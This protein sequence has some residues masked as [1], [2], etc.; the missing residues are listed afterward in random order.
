M[1][2][3]TAVRSYRESRIR[4]NGFGDFA[5]D[6]S[7]DL[8]PKNKRGLRLANPV[9]TA[10]GTF[11]NGLEMASLFDIQRL[12]AIVSKGTTLHPRRGN[13]QRRIVETAAGMLNSIGLQNIGVEAL[14]RDV[15]PI[16]ATWRM[17]VIVNVAGHSVED[18]ARLAERL[19]ETPG[20]SGLEMNIS[21][22]NVEN[23]LEFG[24]IRTPR[25]Q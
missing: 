22:P 16:W 7:V 11:G 6:L 9:M 12:G 24:A 8:A 14:I 5:M 18:Y 25:L 23:G 10:S 2:E 15:V 4:Y 19:D 21:C 17:P 20:V 1:V 3:R 13:Q